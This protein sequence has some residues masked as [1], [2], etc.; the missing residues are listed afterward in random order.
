MTT[1]IPKWR[2]AGAPSHTGIIGNEAADT[3][4]KAGA[5]LIPQD[6]NYKTQ[7]PAFGLLPGQ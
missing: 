7:S 5:L 1:N 3:L 6:P 4:A 2:S